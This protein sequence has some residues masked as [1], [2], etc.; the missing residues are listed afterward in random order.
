VPPLTRPRTRLIPAESKISRE[1]A[2]HRKTTVN[3]QLFTKN[4]QKTRPLPFYRKKNKKPT[5]PFLIVEKLPA[6]KKKISLEQHPGRK[7][8]LKTN[9]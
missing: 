6:K 1:G 9:M 4:S 7:S 8:E 3:K 5:N 2:K